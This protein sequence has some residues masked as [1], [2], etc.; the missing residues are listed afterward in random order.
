MKNNERIF[1]LEYLEPIPNQDPDEQ[2]N[3]N[4]VDEI[5]DKSA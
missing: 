5:T 2:N 4:E 3:V 1:K